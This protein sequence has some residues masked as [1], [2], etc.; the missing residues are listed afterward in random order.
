MNYEL[1]K[2]LRSA[3]FPLPKTGG[4]TRGDED[5]PCPSLEEIITACGKN[6]K[7]LIHDEFYFELAH[8][9]RSTWD[10]LGTKDGVGNV[11]VKGDTVVEA[12]ANL[13]LLIHQEDK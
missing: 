12:V 8:Q 7:S 2:K 4:W 1:A 3:G 13:Y 11:N 6:F 10:V 5:I 9:D